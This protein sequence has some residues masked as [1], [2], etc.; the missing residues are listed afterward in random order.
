MSQP[1]A[2]RAVGDSTPRGA[3]PRPLHNIPAALTSLVGRDAECAQLLARLRDA[4][5]RL[6]T[7]TGVGGV[8]KTRL[9]LQAAHALVPTTGQTSPFAQGVYLVPLPALSRAETLED[10]L[11]TAIAV[12]LGI[13]LSGPEAPA[14][15]VRQYLREKALLL[16]L[17]GADHLTAAA[18][19][20]AALL[21]DAPG[22][23]VLT[24]SRERLNLRGERVIEL[25]G[26]SVPPH[27]RS[28]GAQPPEHYSAIQ[29]FVE[30]AHALAPDFALT[31][32]TAPAVIRICRLVAG[33][34][35]GIEL[36]ASW[37]RFLTAAEIADEIAQSVDF[38]AG[39]TK[40]MP[41]RQQS[42][43]ALRR[44]AVLRG[45]F[46]R[47]AAAAVAEVPL[48]ML[49]TLVNKSLLRGVAL[50]AGGGAMRFELLEVLR[51]YA[52]EQ[53]ELAGEAATTAARH[54]A[55]YLA[56]LAA[57]TADLRGANQRAA[58]AAIGS[59]IEQVRAA[60][61]WAVAAADA[62]GITRAA[63][64]LFHIY[65]MRS[66]FGEGADMFRAAAEALSGR[67]TSRDQER[68]A[69][70][71]YAKVLA[72]QG[73]FTFHLG[74]QREARALLEQSLAALRAIGA[75]AEMIFAL[76]YL[77]VVCAYLGEYEQTQT[78]CDE[79]LAI[80]QATGDVYGRAVACNILGQAAYDRGD[81]ATA[82]LWSQQSLAIEQQIGNRWSMAYSLTNLGNVAA[83]MSD[84]TEAR[85]LFTQSLRIR[86]EIGDVRGVALCFIRLGD[87]AVGL[88][89][90]AEARAR[91]EQG[92]ALFH[93][94]GN[95]WGMAAALID[96]GQVALA[97]QQS[98]A[99]TRLFQEALRL[100]MEIGSAPQVATALAA[101]A[102]LARRA[103][104]AAWAD[105]LAQL[106]ADAAASD[107]GQL[108]IA[109]LL[110]W[111][112]PVSAGQTMTLEQAMSALRDDVEA[113]PPARV[114]GAA[115]HA[116][117]PGG[118]TA[119]EVEVLQLVA[120]GLT[121]AQVAEKLVLSPRT[122]ST[123]LTAIYGKLE[124]NS[125]SAATR[126]AVEHGLV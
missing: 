25:G 69:A 67:A 65:D 51:G 96:L 75:G 81:F 20:I 23:K 104:D 55:Y 59:E 35:L 48:P 92:L 45:S 88:G 68:G 114:R 71:A 82:R 34:P 121:D 58:L 7:L 64:S 49:A 10:V 125:R 100:A 42:M 52:A 19:F 38:L 14:V 107:A 3:A 46:T 33:L 103:G 109:R 80:T 5:C 105:E 124:V 50:A 41:A 98:A 16:L 40:D 39:A 60:W 28:R 85:Q 54:A 79:S 117:Y 86:E 83:A 118:L 62:A 9:A 112:W 90:S 27:D 119:R 91:Y 11:A 123:H 24:T 66:W 93:E 87:A 36:A 97:R 31:T 89:D 57:H 108:Q 101:C 32:E 116:A 1:D 99:A 8:G 12:A 77:A 126:F 56:F 63:D 6:V 21:A 37:T 53:L 78:L 29:L 76:N 120:Q 26:L 111:S 17:D 2:E 94:I 113:A 47:E 84:Y 106:G 72:R 61:R 110:A 22:L 44:L 15:Q 13:G 95:R 30:I 115:P 122:V 102:A 70:L 4:A 74:R 73:W 43:Q 18:P